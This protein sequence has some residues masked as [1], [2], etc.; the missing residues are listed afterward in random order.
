LNDFSAAREAPLAAPGAGEPHRLHT[1]SG[2]ARGE[3]GD[4]KLF[5]AMRFILSFAGLAIIY[6]DPTD[7]SSSEVLT[8]GA[9]ALYCVY[10]ASVLV[11]VS[12]TRWTPD[13]RPL[14]ALDVVFA[15]LLVLWTHGANSIFFYVFLFPILVVSF[16][17]GYKDGLIF[18]IASVA[19]FL[20]VG[21]LADPPI[22]NYELNLA[23]I[24]PVYLLALGWMI[25]KWGGRE[26]L[27]KRRL[28]LLRDVNASNARAG[29]D[30]VIETNVRRILE[31][32]NAERCVLALQRTGSDPRYVIYAAA[33]GEQ[34][35][36]GAREITNDAGERLLHFKDSDSILYSSRALYGPARRGSCVAIDSGGE[37]ES[38]LAASDCE[39]VAGLLEAPS[40]VAVSYRQSDGTRGRLFLAS[41]HGR[42][43]RGDVQFLLQFTA[44]VS[45]VVENLQLVGELISSAAEHER[46]MISRD[47]HDAA[48]QPYIGLRLGLEALYRDG[49]ATSP[50]S[51]KILDLVE[52]A[53]ATVRD[54]RGYTRGLLA[55][56]EIP[57]GSLGAAILMQADRH[58]RFYGLDIATDVD[59][60]SSEMSGRVASQVF[61]IVV[62]ALSNVV[63]H[64]A[65][66][67]AFVEVKSRAGFVCVSVGNEQA[68]GLDVVPDFSPKSIRS[69]VEALGGSLE[70]QHGSGSYTVVHATLPT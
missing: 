55:G 65:A 49:G 3:D 10:A 54:L 13:Q 20:V 43:T 35:A 28:M 52:M 25:A 7:S 27:F 68:I 53:N 6:V 21:S 38:T 51:Q 46:V 9:F 44:A 29:L 59:V 34:R 58:K 64:T 41:D 69:R 57:G 31:F 37:R 18:T 1:H 63:K 22:V 45:K 11:V 60:K 15:S 16:S 47:I 56:S 26:I 8:Y 42:F 19:A 4:A 70:V 23:L 17:H 62:E 32:H 14:C 40:F 66:R 48:V 24:R 67:R 36:S 12:K 30:Q 2:A 5:A 50:L 39:F 33:R 61:Y